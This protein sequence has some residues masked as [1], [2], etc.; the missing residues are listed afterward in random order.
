MLLSRLGN[1]SGY[2]NPNTV[3]PT[4]TIVP[5][6]GFQ[7]NALTSLASG[8]PQVGAAVS[9][10]W[11]GSL[12][13]LVKTGLQAWTLTEQ[14][15]AYLKVNQDRLARG[16]QPIDWQSFAPSAN[17]VGGVDA[18]TRTMMYV[19]GGAAIVGLLLVSMRRSR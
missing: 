4:A 17:V 6:S 15:R 9:Q 12:L 10:G 11:E 7:D 2:E 16:L 3:F 1:G 5:T 18:Q 14:Q 8:V 13:D 19:L